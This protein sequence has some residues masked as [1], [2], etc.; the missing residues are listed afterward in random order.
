[1]DQT[2]AFKTSTTNNPS[3]INSATTDH[4]ALCERPSP[5]STC[6]SFSPPP[7]PPSP[8]PS[9]GD[10]LV[11]PPPVSQRAKGTQV[12]PTGW[13]ISDDET[14]GKSNYGGSEASPGNA[15]H[16]V[17]INGDR[18]A[19]V[20]SPDDDEFLA[21]LGVGFYA[22]SN[23]SSPTNAGSRNSSF[24][25]SGRTPGRRSAGSSGSLTP[26]RGRSRRGWWRRRRDQYPPS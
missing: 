16:V 22:A 12:V 17:T 11:L 19:Y 13:D 20:S 8:S 6:V 1:M 9:W 15:E 21:H 3:A 4:L 2:S 5:A 23:P 7:P 14:P 24:G 10:P 18:G 25:G 26:L